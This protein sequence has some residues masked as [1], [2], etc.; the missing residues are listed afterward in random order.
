[1]PIPETHATKIR[2]GE[3]GKTSDAT[4]WERRMKALTLR[5]AGATYPRI[6]EQLGVTEMRARKD[7]R[8][9]ILEVVK[10]PV[11]Q[12]VDRQR[13]VLL[14]IQRVN[15][16]QAM[17]G[18]RD[19]QTMII[20]CLEHE[21]KLYGLYAPAR[22][23]VGISESDFA[24]QAA[25]LLAAVGTEPL[26]EL[27]GL[28]AGKTAPP[29]PPPTPERSSSGNDLELVQPGAI[30]VLDAETVPL[31]DDDTEPWSNL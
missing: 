16:H 29:S 13:A 18:D 11:D 25:E 27:A 24:Q 28:R 20:R 15:Y 22:V 8:K 1:M 3:V 10:L 17:S 6:A 4:L 19:A 14:D 7:V 9:A 26:R 30:G 2:K 31:P 5:N 12:M 21:A 23:N